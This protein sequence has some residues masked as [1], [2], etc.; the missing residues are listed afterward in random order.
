[1]PAFP[2]HFFFSFL[3]DIGGFK[4]QEYR[5]VEEIDSAKLDYADEAWIASTQPARS[6]GTDI[7]DGWSECFI[8]GR[9]KRAIV[10]VPGF[11]EAL[12]CPDPSR[13]K[14]YMITES[15]GKG[16]G[17]IA[18]RDI[19]WGE[20]IIAE[21]PMLVIPSVVR[22]MEAFSFPKDFTTDQLW[23]AYLNQ[24]EKLTELLVNRMSKEDQDAYKKLV[25]CHREDGTGPLFGIARTNGTVLSRP[26]LSTFD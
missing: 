24:M 9:A 18:T 3:V 17:M 23:Q 22:H 11:P 12:P 8:T 10:S 26:L 6:M 20:L 16:V 2:S 21:R 19:E 25:N 1:V 14:P 4:A 13:P 5:G 15:P 7:P